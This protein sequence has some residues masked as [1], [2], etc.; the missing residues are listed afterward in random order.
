M[1]NPAQ[2]KIPTWFLNRQKDM[3][4]GKNTHVL[5][6]QID[7]KLRDD[8]E[9]LKKIRSHRGLR[10]HWQVRV[11]GQH[12]KTTYVYC[13]GIVSE[14]D[15][16]VVDEERPSPQGRSKRSALRCWA[17]FGLDQVA[18]NPF[19]DTGIYQNRGGLEARPD[20][21]AEIKPWGH[22]EQMPRTNR[23]GSQNRYLRRW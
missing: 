4:D 18:C 15:K 19:S 1:Q 5:S 7:Q 22:R 8:L 11:R 9:R 21:L 12:T 10:H 2:F 23:V 3:I 14:A 16:T 17:M 20:D 6:N 13:L